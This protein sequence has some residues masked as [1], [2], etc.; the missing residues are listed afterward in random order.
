LAAV[1]GILRNHKA[2]VAVASSVGTGTV[3]EVYLPVSEDTDAVASAP[4]E[5]VGVAG[6]ER[7][8]LVDDDRSLLDATHTILVRAGYHVVDFSDPEQALASFRRAPERWDLVLTDR[9]M[10]RLSGEELAWSILQV[11]PDIPIIMATGFSDEADEQRA[12]QIGI[13]EFVF[14]PIVGNDLLLAIRRTF[15]KSERPPGPRLA[16]ETPATKPAVA[17]SA[18]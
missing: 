9:S 18:D 17:S 5:P 7:I 10:P 11:R 4:A 2:V 13:K 1:H 8:L 15:T 3:F 6:S 16:A 14:K 12:R